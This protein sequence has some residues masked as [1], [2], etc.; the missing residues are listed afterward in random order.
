MKEEW[1]TIIG[2]NNKYSVS[3]LGNVKRNEHYTIVSPTKQHFNGARV[4]YK[5]REVK[6]YLDKEGYKVV[7]L[8]I[9]SNKRIIKKIHRLVAEAFIPNPNELTQVNHIDENR[10]NNMVSNLEWCDAKYNANYGTRKN[11]LS[12]ISGIKVAQYDLSGN[13]IK[14]WD[15][16]TQAST[17]FGSR[18][19]SGIR[20]VCK[21]EPG[22]NTYK[23]FI[24]RYI[25]TKIIGSASLKEQIL[26]NKSILLD[27]ILNT[28]SMQEQK[29]LIEILSN[30][31]AGEK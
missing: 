17:H 18:S 3:N 29:N 25:D 27:I 2:T 13:L 14:I 19:T 4:Y 23:G 26:N 5:E 16:I 6:E 28:F 22:R 24:W 8:T 21:K 11:K 20:R 12:K 7:Y 15:S 30:K 1:R 10:T 9:D 31:V